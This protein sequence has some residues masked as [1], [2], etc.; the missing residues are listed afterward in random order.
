MN[1]CFNNLLEV[2][3]DV[4]V[5][6]LT[7][8]KADGC[9]LEYKNYLEVVTLCCTYTQTQINGVKAAWSVTRIMNTHI[10]Y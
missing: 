6:F 9:S 1:N 7:G 2:F 3:E 4:I 8:Y 5:K 10:L